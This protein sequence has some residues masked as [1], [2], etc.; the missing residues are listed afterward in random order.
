MGTVTNPRN[1]LVEAE[2]FSDAGGWVVDQQ[3]MDRMGSPY[4]LAHGLG[5]PVENW[6][7]GDMIAQRHRLVIPSDAPLDTYQIQTG[8]YTLDDLRRFGVIRDSVTL[9]DHLLLAPVEVKR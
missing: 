6:Q 8:V 9:G 3:S 4:L 2:S 1:V 5:V 7:P